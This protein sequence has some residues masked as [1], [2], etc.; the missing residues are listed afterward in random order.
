MVASNRIIDF[1]KMTVNDK[2]MIKATRVRNIAQ[3]RIASKGE[4]AKLPNKYYDVIVESII[5]KPKLI[6]RKELI[7]DYR[8]ISGKKISITFMRSGDRYHLINKDK[9]E[10]YVYY[11]PKGCTGRINNSNL[12]NDSYIIFNTNKNGE[13][14]R[15]SFGVLPRSLFR[16][17]FTINQEAL[18]VFKSGKPLS[19][20]VH[21]IQK[22]RTSDINK[23]ITM[24]N[25]GKTE[26]ARVKKTQ[27]KYDYRAIGRLIGAQENQVGF[28]LE[29]RRGNRRDAPNG[30]VF[31]M[32][33]QKKI[34]NVTL[35]RSEKGNWYLRGN[36]IKIG[37]LP[38][39][40]IT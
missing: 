35:A 8:H 4:R 18:D 30:V 11:I 1:N 5:D 26:V 33:K 31:N 7:S 9:T 29:D 13:I 12:G 10:H 21:T 27:P 34:S 24:N 28:V 16:K 36:G 15:E 14:D 32:C 6:S 17:M 25:R 22:D 37:D 3:A 19:K 23:Q 40:R 20:S 39:K 2:G 38:I